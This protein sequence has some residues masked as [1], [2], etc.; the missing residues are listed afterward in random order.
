MIP[1]RRC[2]SSM[3]LA[4]VLLASCVDAR[5]TGTESA[6]PPT[7]QPQTRETDTMTDTLRAPVA[8]LIETVNRGDT[9]A[10]LALFPTDGRVDD[11]GRRFDGHAAIRGWSEREFTGANGTLTPRNVTSSGDTVTVDAG[12]KSNFYSGDSRFVFV[13]HGDLVREMR[14]VAH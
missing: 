12:W 11:W 5:H 2:L 1:G 10:F 14:I 6:Q 3:A 9:D 8:R 7:R 4:A 13:V